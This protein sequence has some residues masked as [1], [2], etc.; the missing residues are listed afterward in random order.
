[1][2]NLTLKIVVM[3]LC[4]FT[5]TS[6]QTTYNP[7]SKYQGKNLAKFNKRKHTYGHSTRKGM[8]KRYVSFKKNG[9]YHHPSVSKRL[10]KEL[11]QRWWSERMGAGKM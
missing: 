7:P 5:L 6:C 1:M 3:L 10:R 9:S 4:V 2:K 8:N 11:R